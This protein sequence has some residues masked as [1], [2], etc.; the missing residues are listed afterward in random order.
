MTGKKGFSNV[1]GFLTATTVPT[2]KDQK[3]QFLLYRI[4]V[5]KDRRAFGELHGIHAPAVLRYLRCKLPTR[6]DA[7]DVLSTTFLRAWNYISSTEVESASGLIFTIARGVIAEFYRSRRNEVSLDADET[8]AGIATDHGAGAARTQA[9]MDV[10]IVRQVLGEFDEDSRIAFTL[11]Y[12]EGFSVAEVAARLQKTEN[13]TTVF[14]HRIKKRL[15][16]RFKNV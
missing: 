16:E 6:E 2:L 12:F 15:Q 3:E 13:A 9:Q 8:S 7:D 4:R 14:L 11:R 1:S 10:E 5:H